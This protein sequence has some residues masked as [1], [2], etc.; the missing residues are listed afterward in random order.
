[1]VAGIPT[2]TGI[3]TLEV[4]RWRQTFTEVQLRGNAAEFIP[5]VVGN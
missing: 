4:G 1:M 2:G 3:Y 5:N